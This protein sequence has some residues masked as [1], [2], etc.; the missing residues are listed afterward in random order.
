MLEKMIFRDLENL[1]KKTFFGEKILGPF[2]TQEV[3]TFFKSAQKL[4]SF[5]TIC[6]QFKRSF[7]TLVRCGATFLEDK[8]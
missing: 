7:S 5:D 6:G 4:I 3:C 8:R 1:A 2:L